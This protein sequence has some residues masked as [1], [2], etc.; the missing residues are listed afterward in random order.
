MQGRSILDNIYLFWE[1]VAILQER[2]EDLAIML[3]DFEKAYDRVDWS[4]LRGTM[5]VVGVGGEAILGF[6]PHPNNN[7]EWFRTSDINFSRLRFS[8]SDPG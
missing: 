6:I 2:K 3:D 1:T 8:C 7:L 5:D 4:F